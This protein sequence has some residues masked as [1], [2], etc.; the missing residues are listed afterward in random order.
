MTAQ[1][2]PTTTLFRSSED[3]LQVGPLIGRARRAFAE[4]PI[5]KTL[6]VGNLSGARAIDRHPP[7]VEELLGKV[8]RKGKACIQ[9]EACADDNEISGIEFLSHVAP[10]SRIVSPIAIR[11]WFRSEEHTS[12]L[13]SLMRI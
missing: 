6:D 1:L 2:F 5:G 8:A 10:P 12:E 3:V 13:Q 7:E 4:D 9:R 11:R